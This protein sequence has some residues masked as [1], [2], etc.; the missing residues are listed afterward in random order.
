[1]V[2]HLFL[3]LGAHGRYNGYLAEFITTLHSR[4]QDPGSLIFFYEKMANFLHFYEVTTTPVFSSG[5]AYS[6]GVLYS[7]L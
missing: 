2:R 5:V 1:M 6:R 4:I 7:G 3:L